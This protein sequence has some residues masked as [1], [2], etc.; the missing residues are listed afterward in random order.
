MKAIIHSLTFTLALA[1]LA[2]C[3]PSRPQAGLVEY[4]DMYYTSSDRELSLQLAREQRAEQLQ[5]QAEREKAI[6]QQ[7]NIYRGKDAETARQLNPD[8]AEGYVSD[9][10][11]YEDEYYDEEY[12]EEE[13]APVINYNIYRGSNF[14]DPWMAGGNMYR[15]YGRGWGSPWNSGLR[16]SFGF[17]SGWGYD[18][19]FDPFY[20]PFFHTSSFY[21][22]W[23]FSRWNG[24]SPY[25]HGYRHGFNDGYWG[26]GNL[27]GGAYYPGV[28]V[29]NGEKN[30]SRADNVFHGPRSVR[31]GNRVGVGVREVR[32]RTNTRGGANLRER[33]NSYRGRSG[34]ENGRSI[35]PT[36]RRSR[37]S[38]DS[39]RNQDRKR[40]SRERSVTPSPERR[41][42]RSY[43]RS[44]DDNRKSRQRSR[45]NN[46]N[47]RR[48]R[49]NSPSYQRS[50]PS[51]SRDNSPSHQRSTP[52]RSRDNNNSGN[53][54]SRS[55][56]G[57]NL[58]Q[59]SE[60]P[61]SNYNRSRRE[62][63]RS[64]VSTPAPK[65]R[66]ETVYR[67][68]ERQTES[69]SRSYSAP[70]KSSSSFSS[71]PSRSNTPSYQTGSSSSSSSR[72]SYSRSSSS[73]SS[74]SSKSSSRSSSRSRGGN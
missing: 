4:D 71:T 72:S 27:Y 73:N 24:Y 18:P 33:D 45:D 61:A 49:D 2:S 31:S 19:F 35:S 34:N 64:A 60:Q 68:P 52:S 58:S 5:A 46:S 1:L 43:E 15:P 40:N 12:Y 37:R 59:A 57:N 25:A 54:R 44:N 41:Q 17:N 65:K 30:I 53:T 67:A 56:G 48:S 50:T 13:A 63:Q 21:S 23:G 6:A 38:D 36:E 69:R 42:N 28:V 47:Y 20:D 32:E 8:A 11:Y 3:S 62:T 74:N 10:E 26:R 66:Q 55:R 9:E 39:W 14:Y 7:K 22:P 70:A 51:R 29:L 16:L